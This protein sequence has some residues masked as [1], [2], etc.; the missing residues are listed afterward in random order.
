[1]NK[2]GLK[3]TFYLWLNFKEE[4]AI[5]NLTIFINAYYN[6]VIDEYKLVSMLKLWFHSKELKE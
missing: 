2:T 4:I 1:M 6:D 5:L 3:S